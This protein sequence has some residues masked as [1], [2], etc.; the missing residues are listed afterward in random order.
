MGVLIL[1]VRG[2]DVNGIGSDR[3]MYVQVRR[4]VAMVTI[5]SGSAMICCAGVRGVQIHSDF[6]EDGL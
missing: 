5:I 3:G 6:M 2:V 1:Y 4:D